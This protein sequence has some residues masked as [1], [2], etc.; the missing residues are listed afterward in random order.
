MESAEQL[1]RAPYYTALRVRTDKPELTSVA[2]AEYLTTHLR[3]DM[4]FSES[5]V[6]KLLQRGREV[7]T[8]LLVEE[9]ANSVPTREHDRLEQELIDLGFFGYCRRALERWKP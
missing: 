5:G 7:F 1:T 6:R 9:V 4:P 3:P 8:D 2:L